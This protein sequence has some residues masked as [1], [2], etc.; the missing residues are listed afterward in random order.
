MYDT[1]AKVILAHSNNINQIISHILQKQLVAIPYGK[2]ERRVFALIGLAD[3]EVVQKMKQIKERNA[4]QGVAIAGIPDVAPFVAKLEETSGL[5]ESA[6]ILN[7]S[8][9]ELIFK[10]F[11]IGAIGLILKAQDWLPQGATMVKN[12]QR[13]VLIAGESSKEEYDIFPV[14]YRKLITNYKKVLVGTSANLHGEDTYHIL[15]QDEALSK[16]KSHIDVF[17]Y[18]NLKIGFFPLFRHL[19]STTMIDLTEKEPKVIR[20]GNVYPSRFKKVF[21]NLKFNSRELKNYSGKER[22]HH[23]VLK[24]LFSVFGR[25]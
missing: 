6:R 21:P 23:V 15:Q 12:G 17:V 4:S 9:Q 13:T 3:D 11:E 2:K 16:L 19:T 18:D 20:W 8:P 7:K 1:T 5:M 14:L 25:T 22:L 10:A 24:G